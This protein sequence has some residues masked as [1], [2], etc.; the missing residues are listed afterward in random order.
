[1]GSCRTLTARV[2]ATGA[3]VHPSRY[4]VLSVFLSRFY[5]RRLKPLEFWRNERV[6]YG[7]RKSMTFPTV[8]DVEGPDSDERAERTREQR[9]AIKRNMQALEEVERRKKAAAREKEGDKDKKKEKD[10]PPKKK[11]AKEAVGEH[12]SSQAAHQQ[13]HHAS[14]EIASKRDEQY[15]ADASNVTVWDPMKT[16]MVPL[17]T[18]HCCFTCWLERH[19]SRISPLRRPSSYLGCVSKRSA[20]LGAASQ[21]PVRTVSQHKLIPLPS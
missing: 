17:R 4:L 19:L 8:V 14:A 6:V 3:S 16:K 12:K 20:R 10:E 11:A 21:S 2:R 18:C 1:M 13:H 15:V 5:R 9:Q 7:R